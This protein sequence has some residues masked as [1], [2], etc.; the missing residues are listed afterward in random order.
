MRGNLL[1]LPVLER[2]AD[3]YMSFIR[4]NL[5]YLSFRFF[6]KIVFK[7]PSFLVRATYYVCSL[8]SLLRFHDQGRNM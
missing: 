6:A 4:A 7:F 5:W 2:W 3:I 1:L 8:S